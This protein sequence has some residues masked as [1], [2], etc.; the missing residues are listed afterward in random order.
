MV[1]GEVAVNIKL[2][3]EMSLQKEKDQ[4]FVSKV[5]SKV[6]G[7]KFTSFPFLDVEKAYVVFWRGC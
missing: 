5:I 1:W 2:G 7:N 4:Q 6:P 3:Y